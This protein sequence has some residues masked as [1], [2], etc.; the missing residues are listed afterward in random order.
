[1]ENEEHGHDVQEIG[2]EEA[3]TPRENKDI[4]SPIDW[5]LLNKCKAI[6]DRGKLSVQ[7][8]HTA[9]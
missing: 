4:R 7:E 5:I 3:D 9:C 8:V 1:M 6:L 2:L